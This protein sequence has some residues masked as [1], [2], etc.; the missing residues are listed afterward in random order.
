MTA[1][2]GCCCLATVLSALPQHDESGAAGATS[3]D[4]SLGR[5]E[6]VMLGTRYAGEMKKGVFM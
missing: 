3:I 4:I 1:V 6:M 2:P 5:R